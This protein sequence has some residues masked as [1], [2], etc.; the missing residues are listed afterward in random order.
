L[1]LP[2]CRDGDED[3]SDSF[4]DALL[5]LSALLPNEPPLCGGRG[6]TDGESENGEIA[7][8]GDVCSECVL[9][10]GR[11]TAATIDS[12]VDTSTW[13]EVRLRRGFHAGMG[14]FTFAAVAAEIDHRGS[15]LSL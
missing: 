13:E 5:L 9:Q 8:A 2:I 15:L 10:R 7:A 6:E 11:V 14:T 4:P 3:V 12:P 1:I